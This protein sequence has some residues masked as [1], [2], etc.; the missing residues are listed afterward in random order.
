MLP[1]VNEHEPI[2]RSTTQSGSTGTLP[3]HSD[4]SA[5]DSLR[6]VQARGVGFSHLAM[7]AALKRGNQ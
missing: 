3:R 5:K 1:L 4:Y 7:A 2:S 6:R